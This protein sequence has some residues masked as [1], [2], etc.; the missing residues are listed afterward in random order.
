[1]NANFKQPGGGDIRRKSGW[2]ESMPAT[3]AF[4]RRYCDLSSQW[5]DVPLL[6][7]V[8]PYSLFFSVTRVPIMYTFDSF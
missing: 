7:L 2:P 1:M 4:T 6:P 5:V 3:A 8:Y